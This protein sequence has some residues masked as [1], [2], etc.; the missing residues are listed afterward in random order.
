MKQ[1]ELLRREIALLAEDES[2]CV[3]DGQHRSR[4]GRRC[5]S[6]CPRLNQSP[7]H[8]RDIGLDPK[9]TC[10]AGRDRNDRLAAFTN[11]RQEPT[12]F[13]GLTAVREHQPDIVVTDAAQIAV[14]RFRWMYEVGASSGGRECRGDLPRDQ[15]RFADTRHH[16]AAT[17]SRQDF[18]CV[19]ELDVQSSGEIEQRLPFVSDDVARGSQLRKLRRRH[20]RRTGRRVG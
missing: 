3:S 1:G 6:V 7:Q 16:R 14:Q 17:A 4:A 5:E 15:P 11:E 13:V 8:D 2:Q 19:T 20:D 10:V 12:N 18:D 9:R